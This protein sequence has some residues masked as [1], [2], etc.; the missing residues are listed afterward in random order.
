MALIDLLQSLAGPN[1]TASAIAPGQSAAPGGQASTPLDELLVEASR[2]PSTNMPPL[3]TMSDS[4]SNLAGPLSYSAPDPG[5]SQSA[6]PTGLNY[7]NSQASKDVNSALGGET[8]RGGMANPGIYGLLPQ[9]MQHGTLRNVLGA[10]GDAFLVGSNK[11]AEYEPRMQRQEIGAA[12]A[13]IN[14][15]DPQSLEAAAQRVSATGAADAPQIAAQ[16]RQSAQ[17]ARLREA[18]LANT[19]L[20]HQSTI[21]SRNDSIVARQ[22]PLVSGMANT[23]RTPQEYATKYA[24]AEAIAQRIGPQFHASDFGLLDPSMWMPGTVQGMTGNQQQVSADKGSQRQVSMRDTDVNAASRVQAAG[25]SGGSHIQSASI[26]ANRTTDASILQG[27]TNK[28][29]SGQSLTP[30]EQAVFNHQTQLSRGGAR[31]LP[32]GLVTGGSTPQKFQN[33]AVYH[34]AHGNK[35]RYNNGTWTP[36]P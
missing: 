8:L 19:Q 29:N 10:L 36:V 22:A 2:K 35:A 16:M 28:Q 17:E 3:N 4:P 1:Q 9:S 33:G 13:G 32:P 15:D 12:Q 26:S 25:I 24:Q 5:V 14:P 34:D 18:T 7:N 21:D 20:Y 30:A 11:Q 23:A 6:Q 27:L 31:S